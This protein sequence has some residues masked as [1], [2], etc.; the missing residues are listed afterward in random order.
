M[1]A[2]PSA[3]LDFSQCIQGAYDEAKGRLRVEGE[4]TIVNGMLE[5]AINATDDNIAIKD[6]S[7]GNILHINNDGSINTNVVFTPS[8]QGTAISNYSEVT[9]VASG[10]LTTVLTYT[11]PVGKSFYLNRVEFSGTNISEYTIRFNSVINDKKRTFFG[12]LNEIFDYT[13]GGNENGFQL[14]AGTIVIITTKH[15]R[16]FVGDFNARIQGFEL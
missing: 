10:V 16:P 4:A 2:P 1:A 13:M 7:N 5:V 11:V 14:V 12:N 3:T 8:P 15:G 9:S 6:P